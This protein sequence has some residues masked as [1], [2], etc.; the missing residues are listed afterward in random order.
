MKKDLV[1]FGGAETAALAKFY[2]DNDSSY[3]VVA[4]AV[5]D[6]FVDSDTYEGIPM[7]SFSEC[8]EK[9]PASHFPM[10]VALSYTKLNT[11]RE[12]KYNQAKK[13]G[14]RLANYISSKATVWSDLE[15]GDNCFILEGQNIQPNVKLGNNIMLWSGNHIGHGTKIF[16][17][18][19]L[20][21][22]VVL[23]GNCVI[24]RRCFFGVNSTLKDFVTIGDDVF[25]GMD[26]SITKS[27]SDGAVVLSSGT[28][29]Y[30]ASD[31]KAKAIKKSYFG[32]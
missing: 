3:N 11:L 27:V 10:H 13:A 7:L 12:A 15:L 20:A 9:F 18:T 19:Y 16:D 29:I 17:H 4:F 14:Y 32:L 30:E 1:I 6:Q 2:F 8:S 22:H 26:A 24:G 5:D 21:S 31:R 25:V 28:T 23:S